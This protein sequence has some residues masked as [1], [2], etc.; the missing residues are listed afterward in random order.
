MNKTSSKN[1]LAKF[2]RIFGLIDLADKDVLKYLSKKIDPIDLSRIL[3]Y[4]TE[5]EEYKEYNKANDFIELVV[6]DYPETVIESLE[7]KDILTFTVNSLEKTI[8]FE[9]FSDEWNRK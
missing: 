8:A 7:N 2:D 1:N 9:N 5:S 3:D 6:S 4:W